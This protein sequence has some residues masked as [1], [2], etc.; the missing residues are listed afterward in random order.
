M[1]GCANSAESSTLAATMA[2]VARLAGLIVSESAA[3]ELIS[4]LDRLDKFA[5][6]LGQVLSPQL[7]LVRRELQTCTSRVSTPA[8]ASAE[9][10]L[11][12]EVAQFELSVVD[13]TT[14]AHQLGI[15]RGGVTWLCRNGQLRATRSGG[16]WWIETASL[17]HY[18]DNRGRT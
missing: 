5:R 18:R 1:T 4:A 15:T 16:R 10:L 6:P 12:Q 2:E 9:G 8:H 14:A 7:A 17:Q 13:T 3:L 11:A